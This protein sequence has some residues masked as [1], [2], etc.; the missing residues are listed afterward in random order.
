VVF[1]PTEGFFSLGGILVH[2][3]DLRVSKALQT[4]EVINDP[5][6]PHCTLV[7]ARASGDGKEAIIFDLEVG[8]GQRPMYDIQGVERIGLVFDEHDREA[9][10]VYALRNN[11]PET[12]H[13]FLVPLN[14]PKILCLSEEPY[15]EQRLH[16][17]PVGLLSNIQHWLEM[18]AK[19]T[20][21]AQDQPLEPLIVAPDYLICPANLLTP[22]WLGTPLHVDL[23]RSPLRRTFVL[24]SC[25]DIAE[26]QKEFVAVLLVGSPQVHGVISSA[27]GT[28]DE[29]NAFTRKADIDVTGS[30]RDC[31]SRWARDRGIQEIA[32]AHLIIVV[33]LPK[34]RVQGSAPEV[35]DLLAFIP[36]GNIRELGISLGVWQ[37]TPGSDLGVV[38]GDPGPYEDVPV[39][40]LVAVPM[41]TGE[42]A[43]LL[44]NIGQP[45]DLKFCAIGVGALGSQVLMNLCREGYGNWTIIDNDI[46]LPHNIARHVVP[47]SAIGFP[48]AIYIEQMVKSLQISGVNARGFVENALD[49]SAEAQ[50]SLRNADVI[51]D[52]SAS[53]AV[54]RSIALQVP[55]QARRIS[56]FLSPTGQD[57]VI[58]AEDSSRELC[59]TVLEAQYYRSVYRSTMLSLHLTNTTGH[60]Y[61]YSRSCR[62]VSL[63]MPQD[64][65]AVHAGICAAAIRWL[66]T[67]GDAFVGVWRLNPSDM[68]VERVK[69]DVVPVVS[70]AV[71]N[72][73]VVIDDSV[74]RLLHERRE[75]AIPDETGGVL[76]GFV[77]TIAQ[78]VYVVDAL[79]SPPDSECWPHSYI[80]GSDG[81]KNAVESYSTATLHQVQ[82]IGEWHSH[83]GQSVCPSQDDQ[84][85]ITS[86]ARSMLLE[87]RPAVMLIIGAGTSIGFY[88]Q[89]QDMAEPAF[90]F[91]GCHNGDHEHKA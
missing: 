23:V 39:S 72:W 11:F 85:A 70:Q 46:I 31:L 88:I 71:G 10:V 43:R 82:Y 44:S 32:D 75:G 76:V 28:L 91:S 35:G 48:K 36:S 57:L 77:D 49:P 56:C 18:T 24:S 67:S 52:M 17:S 87:G 90:S 81:V 20:L 12:P 68:T 78:V 65:V 19:G 5:A 84:L 9:P 61:H 13:Q 40:A 27:P 42:T 59:L 83:T 25:N 15:C 41:L 3:T 30:L 14:S 66:M 64:W 50:S 16:W 54:E 53:L 89:S 29:L 8:V 26:R 63:V 7:E 60:P 4:V 2:P 86:L 80:R 21:H 79:P 1:L 38:L 73:T 55:S 62:D 51:L 74:Q 69:L 22:D 58:I 34:T 37:R 6:V 47:A 45:K 33:C